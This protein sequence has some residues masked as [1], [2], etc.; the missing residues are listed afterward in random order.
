MQDL[1][2]QKYVFSGHFSLF[3]DIVLGIT[4]NRYMYMVIIPA[5]IST[6]IL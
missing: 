5:S 2:V 1:F 4:L 6:Q 3:Y